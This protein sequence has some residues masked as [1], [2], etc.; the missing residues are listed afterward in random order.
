MKSKWLKNI[1]IDLRHFYKLATMSD[2]SKKTRVQFWQ[3]VRAY[4]QNEEDRLK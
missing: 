2:E 1:K 3:Y 4:A